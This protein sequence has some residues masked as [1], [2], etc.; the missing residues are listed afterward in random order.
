MSHEPPAWLSYHHHCTV[1]LPLLRVLGWFPYAPKIKLDPAMFQRLVSDL[2]HA[3]LSV[4]ILPVSLCHSGSSHVACF[5]LCLPLAHGLCTLCSFCQEFL[6]LSFCLANSCCIFR[7]LKKFFLIVQHIPSTI[8][9]LP[10]FKHV[11][12]RMLCSF[13][14]LFHFLSMSFTRLQRISGKG[15][16]IVLPSVVSSMPGIP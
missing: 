6:F 16:L 12:H 3:D 2:V 5:S 14:W 9:P 1:P 8:Y 11:G 10:F 13:V 4:F 15:T 7:S